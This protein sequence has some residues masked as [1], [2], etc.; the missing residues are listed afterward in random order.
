MKKTFGMGLDSGK[1]DKLDLSLCVQSQNT[2]F[3]TKIFTHESRNYL[4]LDK[5]NLQL[6]MVLKLDSI[7]T[8][9]DNCNHEIG[10]DKNGH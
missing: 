5:V 4:V 8:Y 1:L 3:Q 9:L 2:V 7:L 10:K 6:A